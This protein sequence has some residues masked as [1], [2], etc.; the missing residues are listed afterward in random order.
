[1]IAYKPVRVSKRVISVS[2]DLSLIN[3]RTVLGADQPLVDTRAAA[4]IGTQT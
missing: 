4:D 2:Y 3:Y 1:M